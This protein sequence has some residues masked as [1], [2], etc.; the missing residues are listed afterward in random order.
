MYQLPKRALKKNG[1]RNRKNINRSPN[2][3]GAN[4]QKVTKIADRIKSECFYSVIDSITKQK[5]VSMLK[6]IPQR[7]MRLLVAEKLRVEI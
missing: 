6:D 4:L 3:N 7:T 1:G 5:A 2:I